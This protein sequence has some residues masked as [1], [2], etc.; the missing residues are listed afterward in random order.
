M[1]ITEAS[2]NDLFQLFQQGNDLAF[3][4]LY[5]R[6]WKLL[7]YKAVQ[8]LNSQDDAEEI[9]QDT[10]MVLW[11]RKNNIQ[12]KG[13][14]STYVGA[15]LKYKILERLATGKRNTAKNISYLQNVEQYS[16]TTEEWIL[17]ED[18]KAI[19]EDAVNTLPAKCQ[20]VFRMSREQGLKDKEIAEE[21]QIS[22]KTVESHMSKALK[23]LRNK[24]GRLS[25]SLLLFH[26][27]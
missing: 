1:Q 25:F 16:N 19:I 2:D 24:L 17:F 9:V 6:Y 3:D 4:M 23:T 12:I 13:Q 21:L 14:F 27:Q 10:M 18:M 20:L 15:I 8:K 7:L 22:Q 5:Q 11:E 26:Y